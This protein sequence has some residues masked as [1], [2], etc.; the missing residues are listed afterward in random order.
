M[1]ALSTQRPF[2][3]LVD[4]GSVAEPA[5]RYYGSLPRALK[6]M[7]EM[8]PRWQRYAWVSELLSDGG[9]VT[10]VRD[11]KPATEWAEALLAGSE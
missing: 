9:R 11:G 2:Q 4:S 6:A 10:H 3:L 8:A 1:T 7:R 5:T